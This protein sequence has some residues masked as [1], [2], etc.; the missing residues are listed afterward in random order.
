MK[1]APLKPF[2]PLGSSPPGLTPSPSP[3][4]H[5]EGGE[6]GFSSPGLLE[7][8]QASHR[9]GFLE[10]RPRVPF[11]V[12]NSAE[13]QILPD[14]VWNQ[15]LVSAMAGLSVIY[16]LMT[17]WYALLLK[18]GSGQLYIG[19][20]ACLALGLAVT[21]QL[22]I[23]RVIKEHW[24]HPVAASAAALIL[25]YSLI[26]SYFSGRSPSSQPE[27]V[28]LILAMV[29]AGL[30]FFSTRWLVAALLASL[31]CWVF[32]VASP[33][34]WISFGP[35]L[36]ASAV[37][38]LTIQK[39]YTSKT[40]LPAL[41]TIPVKGTASYAITRANSQVEAETTN[42]TQAVTPLA[43]STV[44]AT[45]VEPSPTC[46]Q[47]NEQIK[48][49]F[50]T[51]ASH[52]LRTPLTVLRG[53]VQM[54][55]NDPLI[56][57]NPAQLSLVSGIQAGAQN[58]QDIVSSMVDMA[59]IET[60]SLQ[61]YP[62]PMSLH[63]AI[64]SILSDFKTSLE[65]R[66]LALVIDESLARLPAIEADPMALC[67]V[68]AHVISNA[69]KYTP[70]GGWITISGTY[71]EP[72]EAWLR[73]IEKPMVE[74]V[75]SDTGIGIDPAMQQLIFTKFFC[76]NDIANHSSGKTKYKGGG[77]GLG[78]AVARGLVEAHGGRIW[79]ESRGHN[80]EAFPGSRFHIMLPLCPKW[81]MEKAE[82]VARQ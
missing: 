47:Q 69:I 12:V 35:A 41:Q 1:Q 26:I 49:D 4:I 31:A 46:E 70:D 62:S 61:L 16:A 56:Q 39:I 68:F 23:E 74:I 64:R 19:A 18:G 25:T 3:A 32:L 11:T 71:R 37:L 51:I 65:E 66:H 30:L 15:S 27:V 17:G 6:N 9:V 53:Y 28:S 2:I 21:R 48:I 20:A 13:G 72:G 36:L 73:L 60:A 59:R 40:S 50:L 81:G 67:K 57:A 82:N 52:E 22:L 38:S 29:V 54:L 7:A 45:A 33:A 76:L 77:P 75:I 5:E 63:S 58:M 43:I 55:C 24:I 79:V 44:Q 8:E 78:L 14:D 42:P 34:A 80:E 10:D